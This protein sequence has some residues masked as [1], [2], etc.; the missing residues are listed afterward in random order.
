[1]AAVSCR[2]C[3]LLPASVVSQCQVPHEAHLFEAS[4]LRTATCLFWVCIGGGV[5][6]CKLFR[7]THF[8]HA[9]VRIHAG[10]STCPCVGASSAAK[11]KAAKAT[12]I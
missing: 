2:C 11:P 9:R 1:M 7:R 4:L 5:R 8:L 6:M 3:S 12:T 10:V